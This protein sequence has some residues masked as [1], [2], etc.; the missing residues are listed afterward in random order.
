MA[1][2]GVYRYQLYAAAPFQPLAYLE[3]GGSLLAVHVYPCHI[4]VL[5]GEN[6]DIYPFCLPARCRRENARPRGFRPAR[7]AV[8]A[9]AGRVL[10]LHGG[11]C[12]SGQGRS[13]R[14]A[15]A[16][17]VH[18]DA[19]AR[20]APGHS[21]S[22]RSARHSRMLKRASSPAPGMS[23]PA[24]KAAPRRPLITPPPCASGT[25][26]VSGPR[27]GNGVPQRGQHGYLSAFADIFVYYTSC[28]AKKQRLC[29][30]VNARPGRAMRARS[31]APAAC[32]SRS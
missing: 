21:G 18:S 26:P 15:P 10:A 16:A 29:A 13:R 4:S 24:A 17:P 1:L 6:V 9:E 14:H 2:V 27:R 28:R 31:A 22:P 25:R 23:D 3:A 30:I 7:V 19:L 8:Q 5:Q 20:L 32:R 11:G 12:G